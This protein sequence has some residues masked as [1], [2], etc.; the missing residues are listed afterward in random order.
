[1]PQYD[2]TFPSNGLVGQV[3]S[4]GPN[5]IITLTNPLLPQINDIDIA[6]GTTDGDYTLQAVLPG[7]GLT[8]SATFAASSNTAD[9]IAEGLANAIN[10]DPQFSGVAS[11]DYSAADNFPLTFRD[12]GQDW[13][14]S[15]S[16]DPSS[17]ATSAVT[18]SAGFT[19]IAPGM[20]LQ[21]DGSGGFTT[22]YT[23]ASLAL[24]VV[25]RNALLLQP[26]QA[27]PGAATGYEGGAQMS[28]LTYGE[29]VVQVA[30]GVTTLRGEKVFYNGTA[31]T[32][33]NVTTGS[34]VLVEGA[35]WQTTGTD[36][37]V[38]FFNLPSES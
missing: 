16:S 33:S 25:T 10:A 31:G 4:S 19:E 17:G 20:L 29:L 34:H 27:N 32:Y 15:F 5:R 37:Q 9:E 13:T 14:V 23:D 28:L 18:Q 12:E 36:R 30:S 7:E 35:Q 24:G 8:V 11:A 1:M 38:A 22:T 6:G 3:A 21:A 2:H 26:L